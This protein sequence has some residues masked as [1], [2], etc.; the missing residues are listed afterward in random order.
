MTSLAF[1]TGLA[2]GTLIVVPPVILVFFLRDAAALF[3]EMG[4]D[5]R[6]SSLG[7]PP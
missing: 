1:W 4:N 5:D 2:I 6:G 7:P 3:R